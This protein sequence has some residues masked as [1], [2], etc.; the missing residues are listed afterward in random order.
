[1]IRVRKALVEIRKRSAVAEKWI[2]Y[3]EVMIMIIML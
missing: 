3:D 1:M 2:V